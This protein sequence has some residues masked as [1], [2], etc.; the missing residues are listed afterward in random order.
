MI[1]V[2]T[3]KE[4]G[5]FISMSDYK[6]ISADSMEIVNRERKQEIMK[7]QS[8]HDYVFCPNAAR[9]WFMKVAV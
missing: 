4:K 5:T 8:A 6:F 7:R 1:S 9:K 3:S 2:I